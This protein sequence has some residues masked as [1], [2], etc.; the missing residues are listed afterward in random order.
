MPVLHDVTPKAFKKIAKRLHRSLSIDLP[1]DSLGLV[2]IQDSLSQALGLGS[3][4]DAQQRW[5][6]ASPASPVSPGKAVPETNEGST[7][8]P[9]ED[10]TLEALCHRFKRMVLLDCLRWAGPDLASF[11]EQSI[12]EFYDKVSVTCHRLGNRYALRLTLSQEIRNH[13]AL[14]P[15]K[16]LSGARRHADSQGCLVYVS[17]E[18]DQAPWTAADEERWLQVPR[19]FREAPEYPGHPF[20]DTPQR[21]RER[22]LDWAERGAHFQEGVRAA[23]QGKREMLTW[24]RQASRFGEAKKEMPYRE[25]S[26]PY[27]L[28]GFLVGA[29]QI[30]LYVHLLKEIPEKTLSTTELF[31]SHHGAQWLLGHPQAERL[32]EGSKDADTLAWMPNVKFPSLMIHPSCGSGVT[33]RTDMCR[34]WLALLEPK[35]SRSL[36]A[37]WKAHRERFKRRAHQFVHQPRTLMDVV[38]DEDAWTRLPAIWRGSFSRQCRRLEYYNFTVTEHLMR[39]MIEAYQGSDPLFQ[40]AVEALD[41]QNTFKE[42][43]GMRPK[44]RHATPWQTWLKANAG[45]ALWN[46]RGPWPDSK[47][48]LVESLLRD[49]LIENS[50]YAPVYGE[51]DLADWFA[52]GGP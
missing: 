7:P 11:Q 17:R 5:K 46:L 29:D 49:K 1:P 28:E 4:H 38:L 45:E 30:D 37:T 24:A 52:A 3:L 2:R 27:T 22:L 35:S 15:R 18:T 47:G 8:S 34:P 40:A 9:S 48:R 42:K 26:A 14:K 23:D 43:R 36:T 50:H 41:R 39:Q 16:V 20:W 21:R 31:C 33:L 25:E 51:D 44:V 32:M 13:P 6:E 19:L 12:I 10:R